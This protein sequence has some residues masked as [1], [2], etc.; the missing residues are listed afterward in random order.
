MPIVL[1]RF[2]DN[3]EASSLFG[4][5]FDKSGCSRRPSEIDSIQSNLEKIGPFKVTP[6]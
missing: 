5:F 6:P 2:V 3:S 1:I 4:K